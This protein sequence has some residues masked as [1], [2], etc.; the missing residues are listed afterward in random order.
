MSEYEDKRNEKQPSWGNS[1]NQGNSF[2]QYGGF[3]GKPERRPRNYNQPSQY[4]SPPN[5]AQ[6]LK[7]RANN[8]GIESQM[9]N[10]LEPLALTVSGM[11]ELTSEAKSWWGQLLNRVPISSGFYDPGNEQ[12]R[13]RLLVRTAENQYILLNGDANVIREYIVWLGNKYA[14]SGK[15]QAIKMLVKLKEPTADES[16]ELMISSSSEL[17]E[18]LI[19]DI[20]AQKALEI[21]TD[22][23]AQN[24]LDALALSEGIK[25]AD[26]YQDYEIVMSERKVSHSPP[27]D[28]GACG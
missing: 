11:E 14:N 12:Q 18:E 8:Q 23:Q 6:E 15:Y 28:G 7:S 24:L 13:A 2:N 22:E 4:Q 3:G 19:E 5:Y 1:H 17:L 27:F 9:F 16:K 25:E 21:E 10:A 20:F 26:D